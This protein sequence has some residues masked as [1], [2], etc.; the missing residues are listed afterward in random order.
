MEKQNLVRFS[1]KFE[2]RRECSLCR[3]LLLFK[4][5]QLNRTEKQ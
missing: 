1:E 3:N 4:S 5:L 2:L